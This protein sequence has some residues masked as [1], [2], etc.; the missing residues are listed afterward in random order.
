MLPTKLR[1]QLQKKLL[2]QAEGKPL[3][4]PRLGPP[5]PG[6]LVPPTPAAVAIPPQPPAWSPPAMPPAAQSPLPTWGPPLPGSPPHSA[7]SMG[8]NIGSDDDQV[9]VSQSAKQHAGN[10]SQSQGG[11]QVLRK[12]SRKSGKR[13]RQKQNRVAKL[14]DSAQAAFLRAAG[15]PLP[16]PVSKPPKKRA[17][18]RKPG[19]KWHW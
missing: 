19:R 17:R 5:P 2:E 6:R 7:G 9:Y 18:L 4:P 15:R 10:Q 3:P 13:M 14:A 1:G 12:G 8:S 16:D 11:R